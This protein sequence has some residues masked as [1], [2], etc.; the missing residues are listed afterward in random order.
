MRSGRALLLWG[1]YRKWRLVSAL[2]DFSGSFRLTF[3]KKSG[4]A[5]ISRILERLCFFSCLAVIFTK[6]SVSIFIMEYR[7]YNEF[8]FSYKLLLLIVCD[9]ISTN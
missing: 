7:F 2:N 5:K 1:Y 4:I 6:Q 9:V 3:A 8:I